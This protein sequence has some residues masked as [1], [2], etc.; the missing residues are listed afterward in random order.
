M[1]QIDNK[2]ILER[3]NSSLAV[4]SWVVVILPDFLL[5]DIW[6]FLLSTNSLRVP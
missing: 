2:A 3:C 6:S 5:K 4:D 1:N